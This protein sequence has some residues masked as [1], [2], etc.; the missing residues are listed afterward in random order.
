[1]ASFIPYGVTWNPCVGTTGDDRF[2][3]PSATGYSESLDTSSATYSPIESGDSGYST[4][5]TLAEIATRRGY[6]QIVAVAN[7]RAARLVAVYGYTGWTAL[8]YQPSGPTVYPSTLFNNLKSKINWIR[9]REG[10]PTWTYKSTPAH[11]SV[12]SGD[13]ITDFRK[14]LAIAGTVSWT[15]STTAFALLDFSTTHCTVPTVPPND[16]PQPPRTLIERRLQGHVFLFDP[17]HNNR[18]RHILL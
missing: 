5:P 18:V 8:A 11:Y 17:F 12:C 13:V 6:N 4:P 14:A 15:S 16:S 1:M 9:Q 3:L 7:Y 10:S 2:N